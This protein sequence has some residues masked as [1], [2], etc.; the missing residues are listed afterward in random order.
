MEGLELDSD[1]KAWRAKKKKSQG[2]N[3]LEQRMEQS[4]KM[5]SVWGGRGG[6]APTDRGGLPTKLIENFFY[7]EE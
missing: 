5:F 3:N 4:I 2:W 6:G 7:G 1:G